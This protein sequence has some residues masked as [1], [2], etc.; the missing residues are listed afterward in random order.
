MWKG[1]Q[2]IPPPMGH[3]SLASPMQDSCRTA[4]FS[5]VQTYCQRP[6][7][8]PWHSHLNLSQLSSSGWLSVPLPSA[9]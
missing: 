3:T 7:Q 2:W 4:A 6:G 1:Q 9:E 5:C 8:H